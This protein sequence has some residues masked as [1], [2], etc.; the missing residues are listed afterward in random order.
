MAWSDVRETR[1]RLRVALMS[2]EE[3]K[4]L[5]IH[6]DATM[7]ETLQNSTWMPDAGSFDVLAD[8][9]DSEGRSVA[10][11]DLLTRSTLILR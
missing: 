2:D 10:Y 7:L 6:V 11:E 5:P 9:K 8:L 4:A 1:G 3:S